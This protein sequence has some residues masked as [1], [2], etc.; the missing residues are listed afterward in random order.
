MD[1]CKDS[2]KNSCYNIDYNNKKLETNVLTKG[3][4]LNYGLSVLWD[5]SQLLMIM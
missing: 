1:V 5:D 3:D 4:W 2:C